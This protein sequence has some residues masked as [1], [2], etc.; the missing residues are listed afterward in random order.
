MIDLS[1]SIHDLEYFLLIFTRVSCFVFLAPFFSMGNTPARIR[2]GISFFTSLLLYQVLTPAD[3]IVYDTLLGYAMIVI[4][5][6]ATGLIIGF[7]A[8]ICTAIVNFSGSIVDM[9]TGLSM[10]TLMD[11]MT[12]ESTSVT[13]VFYQ[14]VFMLL[15]IATGMYRY[16]LSALAD[17]FT[18]IP[19]SGAVFHSDALLKAAVTFMGDYIIIGFRIVLPVFCVI[20]LMNAILGVLAKVSPQMNMFSVGIQLKIL[21]GLGVL[22]LTAGMLPG[23]ADFIFR[24]MQTMTEA[25]VNGMMP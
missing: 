13:G 11:P 18:L 20:L 25:L 21:V 7:G 8:N 2:I 14:Y 4:K 1:F 9:E 10:V 15:L 16:L 19:V 12:K 5:E 24:E 23:A 22:F 17:T 6:A 3:A